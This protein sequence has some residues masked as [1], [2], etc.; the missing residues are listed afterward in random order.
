MPGPPGSGGSGSGRVLDSAAAVAEDRHVR[1]PWRPQEY[2]R[3]CAECGYTWQVPRSAAR[4]GFRS[5]SAFLIA[6]SGT[7][8]TSG[9]SST[10]LDRGELTREVDSI[11]AAN[12]VAEAFRQCPECGAE[13]FTQRPSRA[14][15]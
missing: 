7:M 2:A 15:Q 8:R 10:N 9:A 5:I 3:T 4:R 13:H 14:D 1:I 6:P 12:R 11:G